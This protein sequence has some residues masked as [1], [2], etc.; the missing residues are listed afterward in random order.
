[1]N[2]WREILSD[3]AYTAT[4]DIEAQWSETKIEFRCATPGASSFVDL[5]VAAVDSLVFNGVELPSGAWRDGRLKL[6]DLQPGNV[7]E[8][9]GK[10]ALAG[11]K[12]RGL[13]TFDDDGEQFVYTYGRTDGVVRWA[14]CFLDVPAT[15]DL[16]VI[17]PDD[18]TVLSHCRPTKEGRNGWRFAPPY[19]L[20]DGPTFA[21]GP[22]ARVDRPGGVPLWGRPSVAESLEA[23]P[24]GEFIAAALAHHGEVLDVAYPYQT[25]DC[26]FIPGYG[27]QAGCSGGLILCHE[28]VLQASLDPQW[29]RYARWVVAHETAH[30]WFG[31]LVGFADIESRWTAEGLATYLCHRANN[32][33]PRFHV[34]EELE[35]HNDDVAGNHDAPSLIYAKPAAVIRHLESVIGQPAADAGI[36]SWLR[37]HAGGSSSGSELITAWSAAAGRDLTPWAEHWLFATGLNTLSYDRA[38]STIHQHGSPL[39]EHHLTIQAFNADLTPW[40]PIDVVVAGPTTAIPRDIATADLVVLNA[41]TRTYAKTRL[42]ARTRQVLS[43]CLADLSEEVRAICWVAAIEMTRDRLMPVDEMRSWIDQFASSEPDPQVRDLLAAATAAT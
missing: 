15:W 39:R 18:W 36:T 33:W 2:P 5:A 26:I 9:T 20:P 12:E 32:S 14:P 37:T 29:E 17:A 27:S 42:D 10:F 6:A 43:T 40:P 11:G 23:S 3:V 21:A 4:V 7:L 19:P 1:M 35:A 34:L 28:R 41:P 38:T 8:V 13:V 16:R 24:V 25:N 22:W 31:G 30:N